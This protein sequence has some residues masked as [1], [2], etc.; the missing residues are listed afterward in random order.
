MW[1]AKP[2]LGVARWI[3]LA[4]CL[5]VT[6][7]AI[8]WIVASLTS[9]KTAKVEA[10][11]SKGQAEAALNSGTDAVETVGQ[12]IQYERQ[13]DIITRETERVIREAPGADTP[14]N[15]DL[16]RIARERLCQRAA[17]LEHPDCVLD[18]PAD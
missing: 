1:L 18:A 9:G 12:T 10:R 17:Y 5:L 2:M 3:W 8:W 11:L 6:A 14:V 16:D 13:V 4:G 7:L 15:P